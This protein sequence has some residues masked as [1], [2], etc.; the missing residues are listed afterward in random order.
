MAPGP[1][2]V[3]TPQ[4]TG[5][6]SQRW[7]W[8]AGLRLLS[9]LTGEF[10]RVKPGGSSS[11]SS[12]DPQPGEL[13]LLP[14]AAP[15]PGPG[16]SLRDAGQEDWRLSPF[17][18]SC[19]PPRIRCNAGVNSRDGAALLEEMA[20]GCFFVG[21]DISPCSSPSPFPQGF[22]STKPHTPRAPLCLPSPLRKPKC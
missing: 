7:I 11:R 21:G 9:A 8:G 16:Q 3:K 15:S 2:R 5:C 20:G 6:S 4:G 14:E 22:L 17:P 12:P 1:G 13:L 10:F 19:H 18:G